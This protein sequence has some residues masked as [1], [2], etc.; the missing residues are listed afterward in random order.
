[1]TAEDRRNLL[2]PKTELFLDKDGVTWDTRK[3]RNRENFIDDSKMKPGDRAKIDR[4]KQASFSK[5][6]FDK[7]LSERAIEVYR[8]ISVAA[9][10]NI[11][12]QVGS[13]RWTIARRSGRAVDLN[14]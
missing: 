13:C 1:M 4:D 12:V 5:T 6:E 7:T 10:T 2:K 9:V 11:F 8:V 14:A 3:I